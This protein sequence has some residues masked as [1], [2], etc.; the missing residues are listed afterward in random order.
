MAQSRA[1]GE[2]IRA[3]PSVW[4]SFGSSRSINAGLDDGIKFTH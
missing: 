1:V 2:I 4:L 3:L